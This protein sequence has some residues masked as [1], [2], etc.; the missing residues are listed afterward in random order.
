MKNLIN[1][2]A[3]YFTGLVVPPKGEEID[4]EELVRK[5][6]AEEGEDWDDDDH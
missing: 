3:D 1:R 5:F 4:F 6:H 2:I